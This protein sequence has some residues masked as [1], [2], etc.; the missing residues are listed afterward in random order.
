MYPVSLTL[1]GLVDHGKSDNHVHTARTTEGMDDSDN[2]STSS[3]SDDDSLNATAK[4]LSSL[5]LPHDPE[6]SWGGLLLNQIEES[7]GIAVRQEIERFASRVRS[8]TE[9]DPRYRS[10]EQTEEYLQSMTGLLTT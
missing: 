9:T 7:S 2:G 3:G 1:T 4:I 10:R 5:Q 6:I 8:Q